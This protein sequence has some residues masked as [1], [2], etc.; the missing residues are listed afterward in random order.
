[1]IF[2]YL[3]LDDSLRSIDASK[4]G[5]W[6][7]YLQIKKNIYLAYVRFTFDIVDFRNTSL[8]ENFAAWKFRG[9]AGEA[10]KLRNKMSLKMIFLFNREIKMHEKIHFFPLRN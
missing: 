7:K 4:S 10:K 1:M 6:R 8:H 2:C 5:K 9:F 3:S